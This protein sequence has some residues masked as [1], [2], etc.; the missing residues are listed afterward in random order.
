[1]VSPMRVLL[2]DG[3]R[4]DA[5]IPGVVADAL[6]ARGHRLDRLRLV[7]EG[8]QRFMSETERRQYH[9]PDNL[10]TP[11]QQRSAELLRAADAL[12]VTTALRS[13][14]IE[15]AVKSWFE[16][17]FV[18]EVSFTFAP[19]GRVTGAL[20]NIRRIGMVVRSPDEDPRRHTRLSSTRSVV[21]GVRMSAHPLCRTTYL[22]VTADTDAPVAVGRAFRR[23]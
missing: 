8:F 9:E 7:D 5:E 15:P 22:A 20:K 21:R 19:S 4:D 11:E 12:V 2:V 13:G 16:R 14:S 1:M 17:V 18:P 3:F 23:W 6:M 10:V